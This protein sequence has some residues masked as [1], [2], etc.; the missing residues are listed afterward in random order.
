MT[1]KNGSVSDCAKVGDE[2]AGRWLLLRQRRRK[3]WFASSTGVLTCADTITLRGAQ[4]AAHDPILHGC[5][6]WYSVHHRRGLGS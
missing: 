4:D 5:A 2:G 1:R 3:L 6:H